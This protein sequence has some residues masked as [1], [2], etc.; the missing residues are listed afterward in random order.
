MTRK[1]PK[2]RSAKR[3]NTKK[4]V[5]YDICQWCRW[6]RYVSSGYSTVAIC[7]WRGGLLDMSIIKHGDCRFYEPFTDMDD[8]QSKMIDDRK[9]VVEA[10]GE[11][12]DCVLWEDTLCIKEPV[13]VM[14]KTLTQIEL[15]TLN[16]LYKIN[17]PV[18]IHTLPER[19]KGALGKLKSLGLV[20]IYKTT[21]EIEVGDESRQKRRRNIRDKVVRLLENTNVKRIN[22]TKAS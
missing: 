19:N 22:A 12:E 1:K 17:C 8:L 9:K 2:E 11:R 3:D 4:Y 7:D 5:M 10:L 6:A 13:E 20:E 18:A 21:F 16:L 15:E 14:G